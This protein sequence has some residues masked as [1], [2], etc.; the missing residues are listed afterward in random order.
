MSLVTWVV[1]GPAQ[2]AIGIFAITLLIG[3]FSPDIALLPALI[4][5]VGY[6]LGSPFIVPDRSRFWSNL[7][8]YIVCW[9]LLTNIVPGMLG[10]LLRG[11]GES[12]ESLAVFMAPALLF[13]FAIIASI[14][15]HVFTRP[16][17][18][19]PATDA[20]VQ[21]AGSPKKDATELNDATPRQ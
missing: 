5:L 15:W 21:D 16:M 12:G 18:S 6:T 2:Q 7:A 1:A 11:R 9:I 10:E 8:I 17:P 4:F 3:I 14:I 13:P 20:A 19:V